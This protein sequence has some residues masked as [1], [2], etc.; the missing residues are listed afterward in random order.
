MDNGRDWLSVAEAASLAGCSKDTIRRRAENGE[1]RTTTEVPS[2]PRGGRG[3]RPSLF[4]ARDDVLRLMHRRHEPDRDDPSTASD[5]VSNELHA[6]L[7]RLKA[8]VVKLREVVR[9]SLAR[10][11]LL[12]KADAARRDQLMQLI[13]PDF[14]ND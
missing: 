1:L 5:T 8:E 13:A 3:R 2:H 9:L 6:E 7:A 14:P 12:A 4:V 10:D 11:E